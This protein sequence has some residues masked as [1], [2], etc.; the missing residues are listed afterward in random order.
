[1]VGGDDSIGKIDVL[2]SSQGT[3]F[4]NAITDVQLKKGKNSFLIRFVDKM[5]HSIKIEAYEIK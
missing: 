4:K 3:P 5:K 1:M 2:V